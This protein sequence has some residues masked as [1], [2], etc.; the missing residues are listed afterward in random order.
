V[1]RKVSSVSRKVGSIGEVQ[2]LLIGI[3]VNEELVVESPAV[4][5]LKHISEQLKQTREQKGIALEDI[6][7]QTFIP[8]RLLKAMDEG[9]F[10]RLPEP[11]FVQGFVRRYGD[12]IGLDGTALAK[13]FI[14]DPPDLKKPAVDFLSPEPEEDASVPRSGRA[15]FKMPSF[16]FAEKTTKKTVPQPAPLAPE[17]VI[18]V[19]PVPV[20]PAPVAALP[21]V[22]PLIVEPSIVEP[23]KK[24]EPIAIVP[25]P[26]SV[27]EPLPVPEP[28][29]NL[30]LELPTTPTPTAWIEDVA[31]QPTG[32]GNKLLYWIFGGL[33]LGLLGLGAVLI[34]SPQTNNAETTTPTNTPTNTIAAPNA[35]Q[36]LPPGASPSP[37][38]VT[39]PVSVSVNL[40]EESW[41]EVE[42]DGQILISEVLPKG[43]QKTWA[44]QK[45][46]SLSTG[47]AK[48]VTFS[49]NKSAPKPMGDT[50]NPETLVFPPAQP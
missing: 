3:S 29:A 7:A 12:A 5:Q 50:A 19:V 23:I 27:P 17:R 42:S 1:G 28:V 46:L 35:R 37:S 34:R 47:N 40:T 38:P 20:V 39:G 15:G 9:R 22:E 49:Y 18:P 24:V 21:I 48:G 41:I 32:N 25:E 11:V 10:E 14:V 16:G 4:E 30:D 33:A 8:L 2:Q 43:T 44:A 6:A 26:V 31:P 13:E 45:A 36:S